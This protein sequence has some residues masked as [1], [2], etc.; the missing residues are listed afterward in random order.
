MS[1]C[2]WRPA[3]PCTPLQHLSGLREGT[4]RRLCPGPCPN[5]PPWHPHP[6]TCPSGTLPHCTPMGSVS[7]FRALWGPFPIA[8]TPGARCLVSQLWCPPLTH[9]WVPSH[10]PLAALASLAERFWGQPRPHEAGAVSC[11]AVTLAGKTPGSLLLAWEV[12]IFGALQD[13]LIITGE[14]KKN[15]C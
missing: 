7:P 13:Q 10:L 11:S 12:L 5:T 9:L 1:G 2:H 3:L 4:A 15:Y 6:F 8:C 14:K